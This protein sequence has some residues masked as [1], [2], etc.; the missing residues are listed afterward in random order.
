MSFQDKWN[1]YKEDRERKKYF[2]SRNDL[3][4]DTSTWLKTILAGLAVAL[5]VGAVIYYV[6]SLLNIT[7]SFF[8]IVLGA[9]VG[10]TVK[11]VSGV[12]SQKVGILAVILTIIGSIFSIVFMVILITY[13]TM[14]FVGMVSIILMAIQSIFADLFLL[15]CIIF[16][17]CVAYQI[18]S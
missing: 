15:I 17:S 8:Y 7:S 16:A 12:Q 10:T 13:Q 11:E 5:L 6:S 2:R 3:Y 4:L 14:N 9:V 18:A 1:E